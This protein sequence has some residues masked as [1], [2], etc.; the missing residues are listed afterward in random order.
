MTA[1]CRES[2]IS[3]CV[4]SSLLPS[5]FPD[6]SKLAQL[7]ILCKVTLRPCGLKCPDSGPVFGLL[8]LFC[9][10]FHLGFGLMIASPISEEK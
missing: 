3:V 1:A 4:I 6:R 5:S 9:R 10:Y 2:V 7:A 8:F